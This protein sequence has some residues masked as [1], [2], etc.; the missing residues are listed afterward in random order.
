M[1]LSL[2][3]TDLTPRDYLFALGGLLIVIGAASLGW[4]YFL[5]TAGVLIAGGSY[6]YP[7]LQWPSSTESSDPPE[8]SET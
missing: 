8:P 6:L 3:G 7:R 2:N 4:Q 5:M 1:R